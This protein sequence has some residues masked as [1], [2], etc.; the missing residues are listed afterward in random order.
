M[1]DEDYKDVPRKN[2]EVRALA[3]QLRSF[4]GVADTEHV[5][6]ID[7]AGRSEI[8]TVKG[9]KPLRLDVVSDDKMAGPV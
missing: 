7:C 8:W 4:F 1:S 3:A 9:V 6:A 5:D 2:S